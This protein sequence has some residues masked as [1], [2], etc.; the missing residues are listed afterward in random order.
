MNHRPGS[1]TFIAWLIIIC[2]FFG[3]LSTLA[4]VLLTASN[5]GFNTQIGVYLSQ[6]SPI[7]VPIQYS[8]F[9]FN[10]CAPIISG[11][12]MLTGKN[13]A[14]MLYAG[15]SM[16][17]I[18]VSFFSPSSQNTAISGAIVTLIIL[19]FLFRPAANRYFSQATTDQY[20]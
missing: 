12:A 9:C 3:L 8:L 20:S 6:D 5:P 14:R 11:I 10:I 16:L 1:V 4:L 18:G 13:W 2:G 19:F 17:G 7:P 15:S